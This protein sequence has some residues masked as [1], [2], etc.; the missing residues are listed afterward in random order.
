MY[1]YGYA[2]FGFLLNLCTAMTQ[3]M[4]QAMMQARIC[5]DDRVAGRLQEVMERMGCQK[6]RAADGCQPRRNK[7]RWLY[8]FCRETISTV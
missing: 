4:M 2:R 5:C 3:A 6:Q 8:L 7:V 1:H